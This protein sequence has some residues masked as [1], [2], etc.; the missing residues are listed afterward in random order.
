[1]G[2]TSLLNGSINLLVS[3]GRKVI[4]FFCNFICFFTS[5]E[6]VKYSSQSFRI[7]FSVNLRFWMCGRHRRCLLALKPSLGNLLAGRRLG[8]HYLGSL[9][10]VSST[11]YS[12]QR[13]RPEL[14]QWYL[15]LLT[16]QDRPRHWTSCFSNFYSMASEIGS[17]SFPLFF[18]L[19]LTNW[20]LQLG[21][22]RGYLVTQN[23]LVTSFAFF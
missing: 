2:L 15:R 3:G 14:Q 7:L 22:Q 6:F 21:F 4:T 19:I 9:L 12:W 18:E 11:V 10:K 20:L 16:I 8:L 17:S 5:F 13:A 23:S 1:M